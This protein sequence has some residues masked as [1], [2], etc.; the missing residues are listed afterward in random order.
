M[1]DACARVFVQVISIYW[2]NVVIFVFNTLWRHP[3]PMFFAEFSAELPG[4]KN[5]LWH[6]GELTFSINYYSL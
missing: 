6:P 2:E 5:G 3:R 1:V 4:L